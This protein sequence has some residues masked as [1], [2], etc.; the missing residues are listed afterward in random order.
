MD[1]NKE[2]YDKELLNESFIQIVGES[3]NKKY[4]YL[5]DKNRYLNSIFI[6][7]NGVGKTSKVLIFI[8]LWIYLVMIMIL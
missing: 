1:I 8:I 2:V 6:G 4:V 7:K 5:Q 3:S